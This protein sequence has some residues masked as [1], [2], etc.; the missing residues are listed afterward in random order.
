MD[1]QTRGIGV[2]TNNF[3]GA[4]RRR[5][6]FRTCRRSL[7]HACRDEV[8]RLLDNDSAVLALPKIARLFSRGGAFVADPSRPGELIPKPPSFEDRFGTFDF[9]ESGA[10]L[11][12]MIQ[13]EWLGP[14]WED[15]LFVAN[16]HFWEEHHYCESLEGFERIEPEHCAKGNAVQVKRVI[17]IGPWCVFWWQRFPSGYRLELEVSQS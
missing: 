6:S 7:F 16:C 13:T 15:Q 14:A 17:P 11:Y 10:S 4:T 8:H 3:L 12:R 1:L 9:T 5:N 2:G